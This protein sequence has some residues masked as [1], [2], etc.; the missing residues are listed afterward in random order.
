VVVVVAV[1]MEVVV[2]VVIMIARKRDLK[3][4]ISVTTIAY[5]RRDLMARLLASVC[6]AR[7]GP[8]CSRHSRK[9]LRTQR[10]AWELMWYKAGLCS[11]C[12]VSGRECQ[13]LEANSSRRGVACVRW[14]VATSVK[15]IL[16]KYEAVICAKNQVWWRLRAQALRATFK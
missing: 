16:R 3:N 15:A 13:A 5:L 7:A 12:R 2:V 1:V 4:E 11:L 10:P 6:R 9:T 14:W 8:R